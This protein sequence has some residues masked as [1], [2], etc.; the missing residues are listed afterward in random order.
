MRSVVARA[1]A[2]VARLDRRRPFHWIVLRV[3]PRAISMRFEPTAAQ[4]LEATLQLTIRDPA[5]REPAHFRLAVAGP[6]CSVRRGAAE[7][8]GA[9]AVIASD[10]LILLAS[11]AASW[12]QLLSTGRFELNGDPFLALRFAA[13]FKLP[14]ALEP[15]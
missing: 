10:D 4:D 11:G 1:G 13:L 9:C 5:G 8:P 3:L 12:P 7:R 2:R 15:T 6:T 14:V